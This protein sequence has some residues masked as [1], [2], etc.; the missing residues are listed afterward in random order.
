MRFEGKHKVFKN[1]AHGTSF[2]NILK[3]L[4]Q[5]HQRLMAY[6]LHYNSLFAT[7]T[8]ST[9]SGEYTNYTLQLANIISLTAQPIATLS[10][11][12]YKDA[13]ISH[14]PYLSKETLYRYNIS[15]NDK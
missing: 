4:T 9:G 15:L 1:A 6:N 7:V 2:K 8:V 11:L 5:H 12:S 13:I 3:T 10:S 14:H